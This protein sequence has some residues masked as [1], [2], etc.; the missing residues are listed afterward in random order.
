MMKTEDIKVGMFLRYT[1]YEQFMVGTAVLGLKGELLFE[2][3]PQACLVSQLAEK[4][5]TATLLVTAHEI[6]AAYLEGCIDGHT[7]GRLDDPSVDWNSSRSKRVMEG[8]E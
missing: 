3:G 2:W 6:E 5:W 1:K 4:G 8:L 7:A